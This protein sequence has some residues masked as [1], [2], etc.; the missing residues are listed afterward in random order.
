MSPSIRIMIT[1]ALLAQLSLGC[2]FEPVGSPSSSTDQGAPP[3][4]SNTL[5]QSNG[6]T[7]HAAHHDMKGS[8][9]PPDMRQEPRP[10]DM[11][12]EPNSEDMR[13]SEEPQDMRSPLP[14]MRAPAP[15]QGADPMMMCDGGVVDTSQDPLHCGG[16]FR[17]C[18][19]QYNECVGG[20]CLCTISGLEACGARSECVDTRNDPNNCGGCGVTC[21]TGEYCDGGECK[22]QRGLTRC[23]GECVDTDYDPKH[24]GGCDTPCNGD[25]CRG[26]SCRDHN[27][28]GLGYAWCSVDGGMACLPDGEPT[29]SLHCRPGK[30]F[31]VICG[32]RCAGDEV[33]IKLDD[34]D[35]R[36]CRTYR[37]G[38]GCSTCPCADCDG[39]E[40]CRVIL[41]LNGLIAYCVSD[42]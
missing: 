28:C 13:S 25:A 41:G 33:C 40:E 15:D 36:Q 27:R 29:D 11:R 34:L 26:G 23:G 18:D 3:D 32:Q 19:A 31:D 8:V 10:T 14:D 9:T 7:N 24:C 22:C 12:Q 38:R 30:N 16:C 4:Q 20:E 35:V 6:A 2:S 5:D 21:S 39:G 1:S 37:P 17:R 42:G